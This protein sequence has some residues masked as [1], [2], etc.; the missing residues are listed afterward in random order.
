VDMSPQFGAVGPPAGMRPSEGLRP[1]RPHTAEGMRI[2]PPPSE[3]VQR[4]TIPAATA[5]LAPPEDPPALRSSFHGLRVEPRCPYAA[6]WI[7][8]HPEYASLVVEGPG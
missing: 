5:A 6:A 4:G 3:P 2:D 8:R 1:D 7:G